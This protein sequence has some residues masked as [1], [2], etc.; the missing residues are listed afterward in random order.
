MSPDEIKHFLVTFDPATGNTAV[1]PFGTNYDA[2]QA[3]YSEA[4][5]ANREDVALDIVLISADS[6]ET[7]EQTHSSYFNGGAKLEELLPG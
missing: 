4:E 3:A 1:R 2:A 7:I 6:L 5:E